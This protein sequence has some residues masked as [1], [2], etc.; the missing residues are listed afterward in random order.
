MELRSPFA[1]RLVSPYV[2][3]TGR[4][5]QRA[6]HT[7]HA[8]EP[9]CTNQMI[10]RS[11]FRLGSSSHVPDLGTH[12]GVDS[13]ELSICREVVW[14]KRMMVGPVSDVQYGAGRLEVFRA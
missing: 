8:G 14:A 10:L 13:T 6:V 7:G 1:L 2:S 9:R 11:D 4:V 5:R 12:C 3:N